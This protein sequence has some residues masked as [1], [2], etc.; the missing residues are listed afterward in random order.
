MS[1]AFHECGVVF[2]NAD[3]HCRACWTLAV[4]PLLPQ[5]LAL[6]SKLARP[7]PGLLPSPCAEEGSRESV[8]SKC[9]RLT[10]PWVRERAQ[11]DQDIETCGFFEGLD[12]AGPDGRLDAGRWAARGMQGRCRGGAGMQV[13][14][15]RRQGAAWLHAAAQEGTRAS[16]AA[17]AGRQAGRPSA[18]STGP[19]RLLACSPLP[20]PVTSGSPP[21]S[22]PPL[23]TP[24]SPPARRVHPARPAV[25][26][27]Q[28]RVVPLL[29]GPPHDCLRKRG[30][31]Q[32][33]G[34]LGAPGGG[35]PPAQRRLVLLLVLSPQ[36]P[37]PVPDSAAPCPP[38]P[39]AVHD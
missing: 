35:A 17:V 39:P 4:C 15:R 5:A 7:L 34:G 30:G 24:P 37:S 3:E 9:M 21:T 32:L 28:A 12:S 33:P 1:Q 36:A 26:G 20:D 6:L 18:I 14:G 27:S 13:L 29:P 19:A 2:R 23:P 22:L 31:L 38:P 25:C 16:C 8:D 10:A 11:Q